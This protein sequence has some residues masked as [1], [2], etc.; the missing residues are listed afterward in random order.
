M[1]NR[2]LAPVT[3]I[4]LALSLPAPGADSPLPPVP[5]PGAGTQ[6]AAA[7]ASPAMG[8]LF[9]TPAQRAA[10]DDMRRRPQAA[11]AAQPNATLPP[12]P[13]YVTLNGV[14]RR[15]DG[16]TTVWL[17]DR[18]VRGRVSEEGL[19]ISPTP[20]TSTPNRV[21][22]VVPQTGHVVDLKVGQQLEVNSGAVKEGYRT[23]PRP[24]VT[25]EAAA[26]KAPAEPPPATERRVG[27]EMELL[28]E[29]LEHYDRPATAGSPAPQANGGTAPKP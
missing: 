7:A 5:P 18:Q 19:R 23:P 4:A 27:R 24:Q 3:L 13:E 17:N 22:V 15:S 20:R 2:V 1:K 8:R 14:V 28:R 16:A 21:T 29:L 25:A 9:Y 26:P 6:A 10:L 11:T 12:P